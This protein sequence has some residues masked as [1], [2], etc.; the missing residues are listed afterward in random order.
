LA[1][2]GR[3]YLYLGVLFGPFFPFLIYFRAALLRFR[4][5]KRIGF[6]QTLTNITNF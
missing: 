5:K 2:V 4:E 1:A 6:D 3:P